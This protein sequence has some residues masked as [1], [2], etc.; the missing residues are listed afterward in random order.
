MAQSFRRDPDP[1]GG[2]DLAVACPSHVARLRE[3]L[4][5]IALESLAGGADGSAR[6][7]DRDIL[8]GLVGDPV[9]AASDAAIDRLIRD[10]AAVAELERPGRVRSLHEERRR[11]ELGLD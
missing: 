11:V 2:A 5:A 10:L 4:A 1:Q 8:V 7:A 6:A 9:D 3:V